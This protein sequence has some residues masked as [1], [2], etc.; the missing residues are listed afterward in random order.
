MKKTDKIF[1][2]GHRGLVGSAILRALQQAGYSNLL[3]RTHADLDLMNAEATHAFFAKEKPQY[4]F[5]AA[6]KVGGIHANNT[7]RGEFIY[8]NLAIQ[9]NVIEAARRVGTERLLFLGSS[10]IYPRHCLQP[11]REE[12]LLTGPLEQTN[13][14]YAIAKIA[15]IKLCEAYNSQYG[16]NF[17]SVMPTNLYG[18]YDN[19]DLESSH[20]LPA[21]LR[22]VH[23]AK[24][25]QSKNIMVW[26][27][28]TPLREFLH[29]D[30]MAAA[31]LFVIQKADFKD[32]VNIGSGQEVTI[33]QLAELICEVVGYQGD[34]VYDTS[35]PDGTPRKLLDAS[36]LTQLGWKARIS[37]KEGLQQT[38]QW[39]VQNES[40]TAETSVA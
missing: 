39:F 14:P 4:V 29:V 6:A 16:T 40:L 23:E 21:L 34:I 20:V 8:H 18:P 3:Y 25:T 28:G 5:L 24:L 37:L 12:Y 27:S 31:C 11:M 7:R 22:K 10:C 32:M 13:E 38:Y 26:G 35:K 36:R 15:G 30:D 17:A 2:A 1:I 9:L 33:R 19:F